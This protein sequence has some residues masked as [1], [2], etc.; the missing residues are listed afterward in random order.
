MRRDYGTIYRELYSHHWWWRAR[1]WIINDILTRIQLPAHSRILDFGCG[2]AL[3][4][5]LLQR[6][7]DVYGIEPDRRLVSPQNP[8]ADRIHHFPVPHPNYR[9][10]A[11]NLITALDVLEHL[12]DDQQVVNELYSMLAPGGVLLVTVPASMALWDAHDV[13]NEHRRRYSSDAI[14]ALLPHSAQLDT[15]GHLF[16]SLYLPKRI[17]AFIN[18]ARRQPLPQHAIPPSPINALAKH[19]C[20]LEYQ[21]CRRLRIP[22]GTSLYAVI[23]KPLGRT[24]ESTP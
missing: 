2:D 10:Q 4:F 8:Y 21:C 23:K 12:D 17:L 1:E 19:Y 6:Y 11:Y 9:D 13:L 3:A 5:P 15:L 24:K 16:H 7:G 14:R 18:G 22:W 20:I